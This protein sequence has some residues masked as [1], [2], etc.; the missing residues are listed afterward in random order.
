MDPL[1]LRQQCDI[2]RVSL[3]QRDSFFIKFQGL[4]SSLCVPPVLMR[5]RGAYLNFVLYIIPYPEHHNPKDSLGEQERDTYRW[6][7]ATE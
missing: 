4:A 2:E 3:R 1:L 7:R 6:K 5:P